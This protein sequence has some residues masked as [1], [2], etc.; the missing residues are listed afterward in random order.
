MRTCGNHPVIP[1][2]REER[3]ENTG[4]REGGRETHTHTHMERDRKHTPQES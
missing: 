1:T 4:G 3:E 2:A